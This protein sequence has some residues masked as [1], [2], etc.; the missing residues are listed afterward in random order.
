M[1]CLV[2]F[3]IVGFDVT[4]ERVK[5]VAQ[6]ADRWEAAQDDRDIGGLWAA[7]SGE[8]CKFVMV[9][10]REWGVIESLVGIGSR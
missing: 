5:R 9:R 7:L 10:N 4:A 8:R 3:I 1:A 2:A 6:G